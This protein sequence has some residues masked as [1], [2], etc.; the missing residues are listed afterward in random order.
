MRYNDA[1]HDFR[2]RLEDL[3]GQ[4]EQ[5]DSEIEM[6]IC[7]AR[8]QGASVTDLAKWSGVSRAT[9]YRR[10]LIPEKPS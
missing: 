1:V 6:L 5:I 2:C 10:G 7:W 8:L 3:R 4:R 9:L